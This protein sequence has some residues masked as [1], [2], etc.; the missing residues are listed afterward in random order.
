MNAIYDSLHNKDD[1]ST[2]LPLPGLQASLTYYQSIK[3]Q[4]L[5]QLSGSTIFFSDDSWD[6]TPLKASN[7]SDTKM[8][9]HFEWVPLAYRDHA[10]YIWFLK[11]QQH[12]LKIQ[13]LY[14]HLSLLSRFLRYMFDS[15]I[16]HESLI[17]LEAIENFYDNEANYS[18][19]RAHISKWV[20]QD[21]LRMYT[22]FL[23]N[24]PFDPSIFKYL[25]AKD[26]AQLNAER[27]KGST[28]CPSKQYYNKLLN[29]LKK[30]AFTPD[31][32][33][34]L[35]VGI[36]CIYIILMQTGLRI[37]E[38]LYITTS[39]IQYGTLP[40][41]GL[42]PFLVY[43]TWKRKRGV[44]TT[45]DAYT[46]VSPLAERAIKTLIRTFSDFRKKLQTDILFV[47]PSKYSTDSDY[48]INSNEFA[49]LTQD[50]FVYL[51]RYFPTIDV[52]EDQREFLHTQRLSN[53]HTLTYPITRQF[54]V[55]VCRDLYERGIPLEYIQKYM[56]HL[57]RRTTMEHYIYPKGGQE[58]PSHAHDIL[59]GIITQKI[60]PLGG[61][62]GL[63]EKIDEY[64]NDNHF[65]IETDVDAICNGLAQKLPIRQKAGGV[66]IKSSMMRECSM[67]AETND[68][69]CAYNVCPNIYHFYFHAAYTLQNIRD[70]QKSI[71]H[72]AQLS[73]SRQ[74]EKDKNLLRTIARK[75][76]IPELDS[77]QQHLEKEGRSYIVEA[78]PELAHI[79]DNFAAIYEEA[80]EW[81]T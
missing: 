39:C 25:N 10:K 38:L 65:C 8:I 64:I 5:L 36:A 51:N 80:Q 13:T 24:F 40:D 67:D 75:R 81:I 62:P 41:G 77:L 7:I 76:L 17:T 30:I 48:P 57:Y 26:T 34:L 3:S 23:D 2:P 54:R 46:F 52:P 63:K 72:N 50:F 14:E 68:Y 31:K 78:Y 19:T 74:V 59:A 53:G 28:P 18:S 69:L 47:Y 29:A 56:S 4:N 12:E 27:E 15:G 42:V 45:E 73:R 16:I 11:F 70:L 35:Y 1:T 71:S 66:C 21:Y 60:E 33:D 6:F 9:L 37:G 20:V 49:K 44:Q 22:L 79:I 32:D 55:Y 43:K 61:K 58:N